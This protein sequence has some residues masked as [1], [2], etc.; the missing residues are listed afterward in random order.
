[1]ANCSSITASLP[2]KVVRISSSP[3]FSQLKWYRF[4]I[5]IGSTP[6]TKSVPPLPIL[7]SVNWMPV[8]V[9][10]SGTDC[11]VGTDC[12]GIGEKL[13]DWMIRSLVIEL[14]S[15]PRNE[16]LKPFTNTATNTTRA[17]PIISDDEVTAVRPGLRVVFSRASRLVSGDG[18][19]GGH[20]LSV[21]RQIFHTAR[22]ARISAIRPATMASGV[23]TSDRIRA[24]IAPSPRNS[25][26]ASR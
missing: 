17:T 1:M 18:C 6:L 20:S 11:T 4:G 19:S 2:W 8:A 3:P 21:L 26:N 15:A 9:S 7:A 16:S 5:E 14:S 22:S 13:S 25:R 23:H 10:T 24:T 12:L